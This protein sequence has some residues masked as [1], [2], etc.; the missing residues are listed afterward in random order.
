LHVLRVC[1]SPLFPGGT[2]KCI[3]KVRQYHSFGSLALYF[4]C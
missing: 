3:Y 4:L 1:I 2:S